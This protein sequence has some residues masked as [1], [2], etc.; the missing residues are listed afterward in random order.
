MYA[1]DLA[2]GGTQAEPDCNQQRG[3]ADRRAEH[4][5]TVRRMPK[6]IPEAAATTFTGPGEADVASA[7]K[8][9]GIQKS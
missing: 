3:E 8:T 5:G 6:L 1:G 9:T 2:K 4:R 7:Y